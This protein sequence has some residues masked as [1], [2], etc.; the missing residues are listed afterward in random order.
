M[1]VLSIIVLAVFAFNFTKAVEWPKLDVEI[2]HPVQPSFTPVG[3]LTMLVP[4]I[5][6]ILQIP[7]ENVKKMEKRSAERKYRARN[8]QTSVGQ[9]GRNPVTGGF[10]YHW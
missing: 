9:G 1:K 7:E 2:Y 8:R 5:E 4:E 10:P 3:P 6:E